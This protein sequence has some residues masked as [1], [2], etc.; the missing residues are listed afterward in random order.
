MTE[1]D[2]PKPNGSGIE[3]VV[4]SNGALRFN[5]LA[6][7]LQDDRHGPLVVCLHGFP[8]NA[9]SFRFQLPALASAGSRATEW[10]M[11]AASTSPV[12]ANWAA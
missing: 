9:R 8:D 11:M 7:G 6:C 10:E 3:T 5:A 4:L 12:P 2:E 1:H